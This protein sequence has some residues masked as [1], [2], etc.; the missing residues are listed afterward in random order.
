MNQ[1]QTVANVT[2]WEPKWA[3]KSADSRRAGAL[4]PAARATADERSGA[5]R[6][7]PSLQRSR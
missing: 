1:S 7:S 4:A 3:V 5:R 2:G 6:R